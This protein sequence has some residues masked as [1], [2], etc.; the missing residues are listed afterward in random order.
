MVTS[1]ETVHQFLASS[2]YSKCRI[3]DINL[4]YLSLQFIHRD[5]VTVTAAYCA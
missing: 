3:F 1:T 5:C 4:P 2:R